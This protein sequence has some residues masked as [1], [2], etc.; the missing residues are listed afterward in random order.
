M[1][2][3]HNMM[4]LLSKCTQEEYRLPSGGRFFYSRPAN[5]WGKFPL[6]FEGFPLSPDKTN[7]QIL[8]TVTRMLIHITT[9]ASRMMHS[10]RKPAVPGRFSLCVNRLLINI[11]GFER[12]SF[13]SKE[14]SMRLKHSAPLFNALCMFA[15]I[16]GFSLIAK[17]SR[18]THTHYI[19]NTEHPN[20]QS[21]PSR[22]SQEERTGCRTAGFFYGSHQYGA[23]S[24]MSAAR[25]PD[26]H[27]D[28]ETMPGKA[29]IPAC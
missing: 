11:F 26:L 16:Q 9:S 25:M 24:A 19:F 15:A 8:R 6:K 17:R 10:D 23:L 2:T 7:H 18:K 1:P 13:A 12:S 21:A 5:T 22:H 27:N 29:N 14:S 4:H 20:T 3:H 28:C